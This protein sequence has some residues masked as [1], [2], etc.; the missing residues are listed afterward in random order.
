MVLVNDHTEHMAIWSGAFSIAALSALSSGATRSCTH[1][2]SLTG[3][4]IHQL[5]RLHMKLGVAINRTSNICERLEPQ[6]QSRNRA[7]IHPKAIL[8]CIMESSFDSPELQRTSC[9]MSLTRGQLRWP[10]TNCTTNSNI[11]GIVTK[12]HMHP[13][14]L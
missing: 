9:T 6:S 14:I 2:R 12:D 3:R 1:V 5:R 8:M 4:I 11:A 7:T 10:H 13:G